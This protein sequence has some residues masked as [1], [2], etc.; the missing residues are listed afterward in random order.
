MKLHIFMGL[1]TF[2]VSI[3]SMA[4][5]TDENKQ[6]LDTYLTI[7]DKYNKAML[8]VA[9]YH[10]DQLTYSHTIGKL[11][12]KKNIPL[13]ADS[14]FR[15]GSLTK[16]FTAVL[17]MKAVEQGKLSL[18]QHLA[19]YFPQFPR[20]KDI[21]LEQLLAHTSGL[22]NFTDAPEYLSSM[23][24]PTS[25]DALFAKMASYPLDFEPG[26]KTRYSNTNYV[27]LGL[28]LEKAYGVTYGE[29]LARQ[30]TKPFGLEHTYVG[31]K[32]NTEKG[33]A[34]SFKFNEYWEPSPE[35]DMSIP[36]GAGAIVSTANDINYFYQQLFKNK[37]VTKASLKMMKPN[38]THIGKGLMSFSFHEKTFLGHN[39]S[40]DGFNA[41]AGY[42]NE[43][44]MS[45]VVLSNATNTPFNDILTAVLSAYF[46][47]NFD[48][49][50]FTLK[51]I[52]LQ[53][54]Q[55]TAFTGKYQ[56]RM[57]PRDIQ[58]FVQND[59]LYA[60]PSGRSSFSLQAYPGD[61]FRFDSAG[62]IIR[63]NR[64][65]DTQREVKG[66]TLFEGDGQFDFT[67]M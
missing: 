4:N 6:K 65:S 44:K 67:R 29:L 25:Q 62:I 17:V 53:A 40:I 45:F 38:N 7:L 52:D 46:N 58:I 59:K 48:I 8:S 41:I 56:S 66:F 19:D 54:D 39:G 43:D 35:T 33:E 51:P 3:P 18:T 12:V 60:Q 42:Y 28:I 47:K 11:D 31:K 10:E 14:R 1:V 37:I 36:L 15:I 57:I 63:F 26:T 2:L 21:S 61:E 9:I 23:T 49:P 24:Q 20:G 64:I 50:D 30:I 27:L 5:M 55:L 34:L 16:S 22:Y 32:I 13:Q